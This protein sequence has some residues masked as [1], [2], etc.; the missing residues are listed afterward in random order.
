M[1]FP[2]VI[3][4]SPAQ[5]NPGN[6]SVSC[7]DTNMFGSVCTYS[8]DTGFGLSNVSLVNT[9]CNDDSD[10]DSAGVWSSATPPTCEGVN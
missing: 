8:C 1:L 9:T 4:C 5:S 10:D 6:G 2:S 7:T 3:T